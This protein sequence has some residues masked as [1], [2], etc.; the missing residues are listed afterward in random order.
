MKKYVEITGSGVGSLAAAR[1]LESLGYDITVEAPL[2]VEPD[3]H[4]LFQGTLLGAIHI[5]GNPKADKS[6]LEALE[7]GARRKLE[8]YHKSSSALTRTTS[9]YRQ[10][11]SYFNSP[12]LQKI[13]QL[14]F[15]LLGLNPRTTPASK[16]ATYH[17]KHL[18]EEGSA[19]AQNLS[20][21]INLSTSYPHLGNHNI[22]LSH[23]WEIML[24][25]THKTAQWSAD[26]TLYVGSSY[27]KHGLQQLTVQMPVSRVVPYTN[28]E[29]DRYVDWLYGIVESTLHLKDL[30][31]YITAT[32][33]T[34]PRSS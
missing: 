11:R 12:E 21:Q 25:S 29:L 30:R 34:G 1:L 7:P 15:V 5:T 2:E 8:Q 13:M 14:P 32:H 6:T 18:T 23:Y 19:N 28:E 24:N 22:L 16:F 17:Y 20:I 9:V 27:D 26:P 4:L 31:A 3:Y 10:T 33:I